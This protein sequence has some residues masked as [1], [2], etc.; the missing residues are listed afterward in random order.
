MDIIIGWQ[1]YETEFNG[2]T[3]TME[4]RPLKTGAMMLLAPHMT[5]DLSDNARLF[6]SSLEL[7]GLAGEILPDHVRGIKGVTVNGQD[8]TPE[9]MAERMG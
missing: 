6:I 1:P 7:Q 4:L 9:I 3:V 5:A 8:L 2:E